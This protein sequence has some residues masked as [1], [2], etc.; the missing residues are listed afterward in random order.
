MY[1]TR[2]ARLQRL[3]IC[4]LALAT[5][6][7]ALVVPLRAD[8]AGCGV[9]AK[10]IPSCGTLIGIHPGSATV[11]AMEQALGKKFDIVKE[12]K[13]FSSANT[14][15]TPSETAAV[16]TGH[17]IHFA[18]VSRVY[19]KRGASMPAPQGSNNV[20]TYRQISSGQLDAYIDSV[21]VK[22][23]KFGKP[24][25]VSFDHEPD[26]TRAG[27]GRVEAGSFAEFPQAYRHIVSRFRSVGASNVVWTWVVSGWQPNDSIYRT[28]YPGDDVVDWIGWDP[29]QHVSSS[30]A[31]PV[32]VFGRFYHRLDNGLLGATAAAKPRMLGEFGCMPDPRR[33]A[34]FRAVPSAFQQLPKLKA[35]EYFNSGTW[36]AFYPGDAASTSAFGSA[37]RAANFTVAH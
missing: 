8:A 12:Y 22:L 27:F 5:L 11:P 15:L 18:W 23:K 28:L 2:R 20:Y 4:L 7:F 31:L 13:D 19:G 29:Y 26:V 1:L 34:W 3:R 35:A 32:T 25:F 16:T 9:G 37:L 14:F 17:I 24:V 36:G 6:T 33:P 10:L 30:W 21:A